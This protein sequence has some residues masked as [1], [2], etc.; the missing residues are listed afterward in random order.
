MAASFAAV[1]SVRR[2]TGRDKGVEM[3]VTKG[4]VSLI[5]P[6]SGGG[7]LQALEIISQIPALAVTLRFPGDPDVYP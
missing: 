5:C 6:K 3:T 1:E 7:L 2:V 4:E